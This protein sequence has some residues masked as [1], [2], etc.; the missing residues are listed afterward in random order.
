[1]NIRACVV[2][3][4]WLMAGSAMG[5]VWTFNDPLQG[6]QEVPPNASPGTGSITGTYDDVSNTLSFNLMFSGLLGNTTA[7]HFHHAP[8]GVA[9]PVTIGSAGFP[10][11]VTSGVYGNTYVL[12]PTQESQLMAGN[13]YYNVHTN[14][15]PGGELRGQITLVPSPASL[16]LLGLG[17]LLAARRW[18]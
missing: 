2:V 16:A 1:M 9:G 10:L 4:A 13:W 7:A 5:T 18:R 6:L 12:T 15:F 3:S 14:V 17:G 11:G 8:P